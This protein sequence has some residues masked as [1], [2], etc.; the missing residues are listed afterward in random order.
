MFVERERKACAEEADAEGLDGD[1]IV[2]RIRARGTVSCEECGEKA[3][4]TESTCRMDGQEMSFLVLCSKC[5][6]KQPRG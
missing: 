4:I 1:N 5:A 6:A 2:K 3:L